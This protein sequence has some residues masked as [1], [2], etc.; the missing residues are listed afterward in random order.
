MNKTFSSFDP[1]RSF[2][3]VAVFPVTTSKEI[4]HSVTISAQSA[5]KWEKL[6]IVTRVERLQRL[7]LLLKENRESLACTITKEMGKPLKESLSE[8]DDAIVES[9]YLLN[10]AENVLDIQIIAKEPEAHHQ[11]TWHGVG[12]VAVI[13]PWNYPV[14]ISIWGILGA[15]L[16][17]NG[18]L[19]KP[20]EITPLTGLMLHRILCK[21]DIPKG[22]VGL[23]Q[24][25][26]NEG[27]ILVESAVDVVW[28]VGSEEAGLDIYTRAAKSFKKCLLELG[29]S[30]AGII[31][32]DIE[33]D[34]ALINQLLELRFTN[35]GQVCSAMK[36][37]YVEQE[38]FTEIVERLSQRL[39]SMQ[40][41]QPLASM[42]SFSLLHRQ[43]DE[44][45]AGGAM[46]PQL[47]TFHSAVA[48][49]FPPMILTGVE[50]GMSV[51]DEEVFGPVLPII[52]FTNEDHAVELANASRYGLSAHIYCAN[53]DKAKRVAEQIQAGRILVNTHK[54]PGISFPIEGFKR[55]GLGRH[56]G[57]WLLL[58]LA[59][60][61]YTKL[62]FFNGEN[63]K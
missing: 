4:H 27:Q 38:K 8:I 52:P 62:G 42:V 7:P 24:G 57:D 19:Y 47:S 45:L 44:A 35:A 36:R 3:V 6:S 9:T 58:E 15:L 11:L 33:I 32:S 39:C 63:I 37:L 20:S 40:T 59:Q 56:Q 61:K 29:G 23:I 10:R 22:L 18:V 46:S 14:E 60:M 1:A 30:S 13:T 5:K 25:G 41:T 54:T 34:E 17:G 49:F 51:L 2:G 21:L 55:S 43:V 53:I 28:F 12:T 16:A 48:P 50:N 26:R 31:F